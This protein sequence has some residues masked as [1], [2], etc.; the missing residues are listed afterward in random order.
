MSTDMIST[1]EIGGTDA[2]IGDPDIG[3]CLNCGH[4]LT[5][6]GSPF[7]ADVVCGNCNKLN[8]FV[9]SKQPVSVESMDFI[10]VP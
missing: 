4:K 8:K 3:V 9:D 1:M 7:T 6:C 10:V 2:I 5:L